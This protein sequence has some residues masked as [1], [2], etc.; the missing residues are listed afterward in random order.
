MHAN[1]SIQVCLVGT[2]ACTKNTKIFFCRCS[3]PG[4]RKAFV[5]SGGRAQCMTLL[6]PG[7]ETE[8]FVFRPTI[9]VCSRFTAIYCPKPECGEIE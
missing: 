6:G 1:D 3:K 7:C 8:S 5:S 4:V 9:K 2:A